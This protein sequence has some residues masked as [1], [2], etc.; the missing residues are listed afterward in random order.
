MKGFGWCWAPSPALGGASARRPAPAARRPAPTAWSQRTAL[1]Q[2]KNLSNT[3]HRRPLRMDPTAFLGNQQNIQSINR[4]A[5][6]MR[7]SKQYMGNHK[8]STH[9]P[10]HDYLFVS[11]RNMCSG[12]CRTIWWTCPQELIQH[13]IVYSPCLFAKARGQTCQCKQIR[14]TTNMYGCAHC[15][16]R[17]D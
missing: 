2:S 17:G 6:T 7:V 5:Q 4:N 9:A 1:A 15:F 8:E 12:F 3:I 16:F 10:I 13:K 14:R 11:Q